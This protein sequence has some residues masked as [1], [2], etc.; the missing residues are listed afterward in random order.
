MAADGSGQTQFTNSGV[1]DTDPTWAPD[2]TQI[3][4]TSTRDGNRAIYVMNTDGS[5]QAR[6][7]TGTTSDAQ[8]SWSPAASEPGGVLAFTTQP[9]ETIDVDVA[10][11]PPV[12]IAIEDSLGNPIGSETDTVTIASTANSAGADLRRAAATG[13][14]GGTAAIDV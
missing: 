12:R 4:F 1:S 6:L 8:P 5:G 2:G 7:T 10:I 13:A 11:S 3:A 14:V 9:P